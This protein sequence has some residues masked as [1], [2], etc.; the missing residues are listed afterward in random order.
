MISQ[1]DRE[2]KAYKEG[3]KEVIFTTGY[4]KYLY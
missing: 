3:C 2:H 4:T 1:R